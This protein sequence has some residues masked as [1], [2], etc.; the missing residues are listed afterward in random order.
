MKSIDVK[1]RRLEKND[2]FHS[3][4]WRNDPDIWTATISSPTKKIKITD[5]LDWIEKVLKEKNSKRFA[6]EADGK[7]V[8]NVQLTNIKNEESYFGIF[9][10]DKSF[11]GKGVGKIATKLIL[12]FA[13]SKLLL[14]KVKLKVRKE[15]IAAFNIYRKT[16]FETQSVQDGVIFMEL[17]RCDFLD[18]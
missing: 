14:N 8:G 6:I 15:N 13:F 7:Y 18:E 9:I 11:W 12:N 5:E 10:G 17:K 3:V 1:L 2:A 4:I 16:G